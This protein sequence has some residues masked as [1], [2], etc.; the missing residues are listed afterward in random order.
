VT[1]KYEETISWASSP[2]VRKSMLGNKSRDTA[3]EMVVRRYLHN[4]GFRYRVHTRPIKDWNRKADMV[5]PRVKVAVFI[6]GCFWHGCSK[7][8]VKPKT[9][10]DYWSKKIER[11]SERDIETFRRLRSKG[12]SVITLWE[13]QDLIKGAKRIALRVQSRRELL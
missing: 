2:A 6:N 5:F 7:H 9:N 13:H 3:P 11:N 4:Q 10:S 8:Y 1:S 12:W